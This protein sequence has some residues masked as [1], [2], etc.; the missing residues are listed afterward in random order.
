MATLTLTIKTVK[1]SYQV[2]VADTATILEL[3]QAVEKESQ[4]PPDEQRLIYAGHILKDEDTVQ[5][6][7]KGR[8]R[9]C[10]CV[11]VAVGVGFCLWASM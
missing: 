11:C 3:K 7:G 9:V 8:R 6:Y 2:S 5:K 10:L 1:D 4:I